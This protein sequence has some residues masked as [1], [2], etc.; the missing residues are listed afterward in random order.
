MGKKDPRIDAY[1]KKA[2]PFAQPILVHLR[3]IVHTACPDVEETMKWSFPHF[4]YQGMLAGMASFKQHATFGFWKGGLI[5]DKDT[6]KSTEAMGQFGKITSLADLPS[7][8]TIS[9]YVKQA[10]VLN[11][12]GIKVPKSKQ[13]T[14]PRTPLPV[15]PSLT[16]ALKR[17]ALARKH[18][19]AFVPSARFEYIEWITEARTDITRQR[20]VA[21]TVAQLS[22]G[23]QRHW[24]YQTNKA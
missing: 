8:A 18:F 6:S 10:M 2:A 16:A 17:N 12:N 7:K 3:E 5:I 19:E 22:K 9:G 11:E 24:K 13:K 23:L 14:A 4:M 1:I 15:P 21:T 20:R